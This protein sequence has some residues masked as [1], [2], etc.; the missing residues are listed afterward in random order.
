MSLHD[1][2]KV[3][4][5]SMLAKLNVNLKKHFK[6]ISIKWKKLNVNLKKHFKS[7]SIKWKNLNKLILFSTSISHGL[8]IPDLQIKLCYNQLKK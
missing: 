7:I 4:V 5:C 1:V 8:E 2:K 6:S 3:V